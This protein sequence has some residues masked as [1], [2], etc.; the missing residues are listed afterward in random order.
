MKGQEGGGEF[1]DSLYSKIQWLMFF[2]AVVATLLLGATA[3]VQIKESQTFHHISPFALYFFIGFTYALTLIYAFLLRR[4]QRLKVFAYG[5]ILADVFFVTLLIY[6]TGGIESVFSWV[7]LLPIFGASAILYRRGGLL[8]ASASSILYGTLLDLEFYQVILPL[9][10]R[11][12]L[13]VGYKSSY[14]FYLMAVNIIAF[15]LVAILSA[16]LSEQVRRKDEEL[17]ERLIDYSELER[18]Y[19]H[20]VQNVTSGLITVDRTGRVTSFNR[21]AEE[22]TGHTLEEVYQKE[23]GNL[24]PGFLN[25]SR[26]NGWVSEK[27]WKNFYFPRWETNFQRKDGTRLTLGFSASPLKDSEDHEIGVI[28][29]FQDLTKLREMEEDLKRADRL[30]AIGTLAAGMAHEIRNPLAS[31][32]GSIEIL[33]EEIDGAV[34]HQQLMDIILREVGRL[35]SLIADFLLFARPTPPGKELIHLNGIVEEVLKVFVHSPE[36]GPEIRLV[37]HFQDEIYLPG[38]AQQIKQVF[39]NLIIN[40]AQAMPTGGEL[41]VELRR[42]SF[43][44]D[45]E[46]P[47]QVEIAISD[48]GTGIGAEELDKIFNP[49]FTTKEKGTGLGLSIVHKIVEGYGGKITVRSQP[50]KGTTFTIYLPVQ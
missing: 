31:I 4:I 9:G 7:Y 45:L 30:A 22:I 34:Q 13:P 15:Y 18:L 32:S 23:I 17:R 33:K 6:F 28:F 38:D 12:A 40:A 48:T 2:R 27:E 14:V 16:Y 8:V 25:L 3:I 36:Y 21:M 35:N 24:F 42:R 44:S 1:R 43:P 5:Q 49:F 50:N 20:I 47:P 41:R 46:E 11:F 26:S 10:S 39:W 29:I 37:P 19:K